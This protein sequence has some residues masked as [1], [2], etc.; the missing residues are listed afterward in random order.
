MKKS[1]VP[2]EK[3][4]LARAEALEEHANEIFSAN[5]P[6]ADTLTMLSSQFRQLALE[7]HEH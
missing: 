7:L 2:L 3:A 6:M 5:L 1:L 4:L